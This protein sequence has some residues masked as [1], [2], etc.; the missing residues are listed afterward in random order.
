MC[1]TARCRNR[2]CGTQ[3]LER[4]AKGAMGL[5]QVLGEGPL[6]HRPR[7]RCSNGGLCRA[8][9]PGTNARNRLI[10]RPLYAQFKFW[11]HKA[12]PVLSKS[13][14]P[15][16]VASDLSGCEDSPA[17]SLSRVI[18]SSPKR[19]GPPIGDKSAS[20]AVSAGGVTSTG[21]RGSTISMPP[22]SR[23][24]PLRPPVRPTRRPGRAGDPR[25]HSSPRCAARARD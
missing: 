15:V 16:V 8:L 13:R 9:A 10:V 25:H 12:R 23:G 24:L 17:P 3:P 11:S 22:R 7:A 19:L 6:Q 18:V 5:L 1:R 2:E 20:P 4:T 21:A 14:C